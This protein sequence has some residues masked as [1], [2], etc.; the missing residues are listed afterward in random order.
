[1]QITYMQKEFVKALK[2]KIWVNIMICIL[3]IKHYFWLLFLKTGAP[4]VAWQ[5][6][7]KIK[8]KLKFLTDIDMLL[9]VEKGI[10]GRICHSSNRYVKTNNKYMKDYDKNKESSY[11]KFWNVNSLYV[12]AM[13]QKLSAN[14]FKLIE[15]FLNLMKAL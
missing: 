6:A 8:V 11:L 10:R 4:E 15:V 3:K 13:P 1:M 9:M 12:W 7:L 5:A 14:D 2:Y